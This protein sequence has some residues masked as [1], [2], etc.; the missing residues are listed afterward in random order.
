MKETFL[1]LLILFVQTA[2]C[3][4]GVSDGL[5]S[6]P[7]KIIDNEF[8]IE[9]KNNVVGTYQVEKLEIDGSTIYRS[10]SESTLRFIGTVHAQYELESVFKDN[11]LIRSEVRTFKNGTLDS[12]T[13]TSLV[14]S[15]YTIIMDGNSST[16]DTNRIDKSVVQLYFE[17]PQDGDRFFSEKDGSFKV[18]SKI[19][20]SEF[21]L[22]KSN[23]SI[24]KYKDEKLERVD[25]SFK[26]FQYSILRRLIQ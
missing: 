16:I 22:G 24:F 15:H 6:K 13:I 1:I 23:P 21:K 20:D 25:I 5:S 7:K 2:V 9:F 14:G 18:V 8:Q 3:Q 4:R 17:P 19:G 26:V 11:V 10:N 12:E